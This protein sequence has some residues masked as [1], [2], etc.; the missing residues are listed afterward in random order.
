MRLPSAGS[1][2]G[3]SSFI[4]GVSHLSIVYSKLLYNMAGSF[5][6]VKPQGTSTNPASVCIVFANVPRVRA[7][8]VTRSSITGGR[9]LHQGVTIRKCGTV[10]TTNVVVYHVAFGSI[11]VSSCSRKQHGV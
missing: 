5:Q 1:W 9:G 11:V 8:H 6:E 7:S 3:L 4:Y 2:R 10:G